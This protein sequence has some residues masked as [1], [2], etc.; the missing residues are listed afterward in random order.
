VTEPRETGP[1]ALFDWYRFANGFH[2]GYCF[3]E[4]S[5][6]EIGPDCAELLP[7]VAEAGLAIGCQQPV[8]W[9]SDWIGTGARDF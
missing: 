6:T 3:P 2:S 5:L 1:I 9:A 8:F 4:T 7:E